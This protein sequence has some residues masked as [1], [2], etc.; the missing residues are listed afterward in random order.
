VH[1]II[2]ALDPDRQ[3]AQAR[4]MYGLTADQ[5][6]AET[7]LKQAAQALVKEAVEPLASKPS[8][9]QLLQDIKREL[10][11]VIDEISKDELLEAGT[12]AEAKAKAKALVA[13]F[14]QFLADHKD[15]ID[16]L[17]FFFR[18]PH[19]ERLRYDDIKALAA[20]IKA[21]P[22]SWTPEVLWRAYEVLERDKV[23]GA[24]GKRLLTDIV[25]LVRF[26]LRQDDELVPHAE[27]VRAR[28]QTWM[29]QQE[30]RA[31]PFTEQQVRWLEMI[32]DHVATSLEIAIEDFDAVPFAQE[33]GLGR[34]SQVFGRELEP[35][36][37]EL[38][39]V[40]AA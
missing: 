19:R 1:A 12:S 28:F 32:C 26:A 33:G 25:S 3:Q 21:P 2:E 6:P 35:L 13:S 10:E 22:R 9:R 30:N 11:Q 29:S 40:L 5:E 8:L 14:E 24:S 16:A 37:L 18:V 15:E 39:Q 36:L 20:T 23:R 17:Q 34:A 38:N 27:R 31:R 4:S 7:Q